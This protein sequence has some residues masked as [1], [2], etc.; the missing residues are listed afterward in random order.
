MTMWLREGTAN[1][2]ATEA[3]LDRPRHG[4]GRGPEAHE[5]AGDVDMGEGAWSRDQPGGAGPDARVQPEGAFFRPG[6]SPADGISFARC[7]LAWG[8]ARA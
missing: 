1:W 3:G 2:A 6:H 8:R 7:N 5:S 4:G